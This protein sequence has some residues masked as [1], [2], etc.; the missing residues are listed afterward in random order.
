MKFSRLCLASA[1][2]L[3]SFGRE[4]LSRLTYHQNL[5]F[6]TILKIF[7][8]YLQCLWRFTACLDS[9]FN[10]EIYWKLLVFY[11]QFT[12]LWREDETH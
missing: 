10:L 7:L 4:T 5:R 6:Y 8:K 11:L 3:F 12:Y 9:I 1:D 2:F